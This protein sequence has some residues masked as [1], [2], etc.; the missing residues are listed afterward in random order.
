MLNQVLCGC[1]L[2][3][4]ET[5]AEMAMLII[6][7]LFGAALSSMLGSVDIVSAL[8]LAGIVVFLIRP[9]VLAVVLFKA[10]MSWAAC[11]FI[12]WFGPRDLNSMLL[13][14]L[15]VLAA[16]PGGELLFANRGRGRDDLRGAAWRVTDA[17]SLLVRPQGTERD[18][19]RRAEN[20]AA[21]LFG[22]EADEPDRL[23]PAGL[24][25]RLGGEVPPLIL[26]VRSRSSYESDGVRIP[27]DVCVRPR[28]GPGLGGR[29]S[30]GPTGG[31]LLHLKERSNERPCGA[32]AQGYRVTA[33]ALVGGLD[34]WRAIY[35]VEPIAEVQPAR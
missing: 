23:D 2:E 31:R 10:R 5:T 7:I 30:T 29:A 12:C 15:V 32:A 4:D 21:A 3:Y 13:A 20:T 1:F 27:G 26:D 6:F 18:A 14:L 24:H 17:D 11:G 8:V 28:P 16:I 9:P 25:S 34:V 19:G 35:P 33:S 22:V